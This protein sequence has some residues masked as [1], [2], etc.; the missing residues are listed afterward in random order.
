MNNGIIITD[1][2][3]DRIYINIIFEGYDIE[4]KKIY[5]ISKKQKYEFD[6]EKI[7]ANKCKLVLNITNIKDGKMFS[8][9]N[10]S[11]KEEV[12]GNLKDIHI[13]V[14]L[15]YK[16]ED[17]DR[18]YRYKKDNF[19]YTINFEVKSVEEEYFS[20]SLKSRFLKENE[21]FNNYKKKKKY[22]KKFSVLVAKN[23]LN[24][25]Y[26][27]F[28][29]I[30]P[31]KEKRILLMSETRSP[32]SG[33]L[34]ALD[35]RIKQRKINENYKIEYSFFKTLESKKAKMI[36]NWI[37]LLWKISKQQ[38]IFLDDYSPLFKFI[39]LNKNTKLI[40]VWHAGVGFKSVGYARFGF[41][42]P[43][44]Y[45]SCH[46]KYDYAIV[47]SEALI[48]VYQEVFGI[49]ADKILPYGLPRLDN[50]LDKNRMQE[51]KE[52]LYNTYSYLK[53]NKIIIFAPT[54]R[55]RGQEKA[56]YPYEVLDL[57]KIYELC[58]KQ[59]YIFIIKMHP[60]VRKQIIIPEEFQDRIIDFSGYSDINDLL[61]VADILITDYSS[62]I[63][64]FS[65]LKK[66]ILFYTFDLDRY[67]LINKVHRSL[68]EYAPG[69][70]CMNID[71]LINAIENQDF[72]IEKLEKFV[73]E[74]FNK[75]DKKSTDL[76]IDNIIL[77]GDKDVK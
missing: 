63:Y 18:I 61:Y 14:D 56:Y 41:G 35:E 27:V 15:A 55:G 39:N 54:F 3:W 13:T 43:E 68:R 47:G 60:F 45:N 52:K 29:A 62:N 66:P 19:A 44:P 24:C 65:L 70:I 67:Q 1:I 4:N 48:P 16:L 6:L 71:E 23:V 20:I 36:L 64:D 40:Q 58:K 51:I 21:E 2:F 7:D 50:Y 33:N 17:L 34:K 77:K 75:T 26:K 31:K 11:F 25:I 49:S 73:Q 9:D 59:G 42:G 46:R 38:Y 69:K 76:I 10:Y 22:I 74:N 8:N 72:E 5:V 37:K 30:H 32:I 28:S 57:N 53:E 12:D